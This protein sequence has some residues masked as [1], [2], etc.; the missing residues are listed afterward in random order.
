[1]VLVKPLATITLLETNTVL[2]KSFYTQQP[3]LPEV[4]TGAYLNF[5]YMTTATPAAASL[6]GYVDFAW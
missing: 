2:E 5:I 4:K 1:V 6:I 3:A